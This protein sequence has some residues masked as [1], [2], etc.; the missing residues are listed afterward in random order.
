MRDHSES[1]AHLRDFAIFVACAM[2]LAF[3]I[4]HFRPGVPWFVRV[5]V[6][7]YLAIVVWLGIRSI[8]NFVVLY[9]GGQ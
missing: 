8:A 7:L 3:T 5:V 2:L 1:F 4:C 9:R 6:Y